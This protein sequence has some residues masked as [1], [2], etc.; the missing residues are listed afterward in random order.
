MKPSSRVGGVAAFVVVHLVGLISNLALLLRVGFDLPVPAHCHPG[1]ELI[2]QWIRVSPAER[3]ILLATGMAGEIHTLLLG[4]HPAPA[5]IISFRTAAGECSKS[6]A[7]VTK[8]SLFRFVFPR[9]A[10]RASLAEEL[11]SSLR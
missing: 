8:T 11:S 10:M 9:S 3:R 2:G 7:A 4:A 1:P 6:F 5:G